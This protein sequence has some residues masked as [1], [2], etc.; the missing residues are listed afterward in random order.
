MFS[1]SLELDYIQDFFSVKNSKIGNKNSALMKDVLPQDLEFNCLIVSSYVLPET[2]Q[3]VYYLFLWN[4]KIISPINRSH[5]K[6]KSYEN[7][8]AVVSC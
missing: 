3:L 8:D 4:I 6:L 7:Y 5:T 2:L 1:R